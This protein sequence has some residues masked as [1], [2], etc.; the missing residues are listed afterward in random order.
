M[1]RLGAEII[2][3]LGGL[4]VEREALG[5][6]VTLRRGEGVA[7]RIDLPDAEDSFRFVRA[8]MRGDESDPRNYDP[9]C[10]VDSGRNSFVDVR[11]IRLVVNFDSGLSVT[12]YQPERDQGEH[13]ETLQRRRDEALNI[14]A[15]F[16]AAVRLEVG[17][18]WV[19]PTG[20]FPKLV[21]PLGLV[22]L[23]ASK[24]F[25]VL[26]APAG[27]IRIVDSATL[28]TEESLG[29]LEARLSDAA[30]QPEEILLSEALYLAESEQQRAAD[31]ATLLSAIAVELRTKRV[32]RLIVGD[33][34]QKI[35]ELLLNNPRDWS[36]AAHGLYAKALPEFAGN[37]LGDGHKE[38]AKQVQRLFDARNRIAHRGDVVSVEDGK[39][40]VAAARNAFAILQQVLD[41]ARNDT[42]DHQASADGPGTT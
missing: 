14:A 23:D 20:E 29:H 22:D 27:V 4:L 38:S 3:E 42:D 13:D 26:V 33:S 30:L 16:C 24:T 25:G 7:W 17:Q 5:K 31:R 39:R 1:A 28:V 2:V 15:D 8:K 35:L 9:V 37:D 32:L 10:L 12:D 18:H 6:S 40:H 19:E 41:D 34:R 11:M 21:G 36:M